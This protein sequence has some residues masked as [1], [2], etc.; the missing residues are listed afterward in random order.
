MDIFTVLGALAIPCIVCFVIGLVLLI[1][2]M[3]I[4]GF[5]ACGCL[6]IL[7]FLAVIVM[8]FASNSF[9]T[10]IIITAIMLLVLTLVIVLFLHSFQRG[11]LSRSPIV[12]HQ[13]IE[14][15]KEPQ[16]ETLVGKQG[17]TLTPL[18]PTGMAEI[19]GRR[20]NVETAGEFIPAGTTVTVVKE[21]GL[22]VLV[23]A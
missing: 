5:G 11:L 3:F 1:V 12:N 21:G 17:V 14:K 18:R 10:A 4:P 19:D 23:Q 22:S 7:S 2:E 6:G 15:Q 8:Q 9:S 16:K 13:V 20:I